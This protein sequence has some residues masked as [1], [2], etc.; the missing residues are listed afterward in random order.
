MPAAVAVT[1][2]GLLSGTAAGGVA[3]LAGTTGPALWVQP[4]VAAGAVPPVAGVHLGLVADARQTMAVSWSTAVSVNRAVLD[5][6]TT[7]DYG[8][9]LAGDD[10]PSKDVRTVYHHVGIDGLAPGTTYFYRLRHTG[11][12]PFTGSFT[13]AP[14]ARSGFRFALLGDMGVTT[15][16]AD[17]IALIRRQRPALAFVAGDL[18]YADAQGTGTGGSQTQDF[19]LWDRWFRQIQ[20]SAAST[21]WMTTVGNHEMEAGNG[22]LGYDGYLDRFEPPGNGAGAGGTTY[23]FVRGNVGFVALDGNDASYEIPTN[24]GYLGSEQD[25]WLVDTLDALR[26]DPAVDFVVVGFHNCAYCSSLAHGS[27]GG[28]RDR[29][30]A[31]FDRFEVDLVVNGH[32]HCYERTHPVRAG[33]PVTVA[34]TGATIDSSRG[35]TYLTAGSGGQSLG[36]TVP[37]QPYVV[38]ADRDRVPETAD[39]SAISKREH[40]IVFVDAVPRNGQGFAQ[41]RLQV[42]TSGDLVLDQVVLRRK[43]RRWAGVAA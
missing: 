42:L 14:L 1:R 12:T 30:G 11:A 22:E 15:K 2:R 25:T 23:S 28:I 13:T 3:A 35:T 38:D 24:R 7:T 21:P 26:R 8:T 19:A 36:S 10:R 27:D 33:L 5:L 31:I 20:S 4:S 43:Y 16:A 39:W 40:C 9:T 37:G 17:N 6:G 32:N 18:S 41:L 29:W 34:P